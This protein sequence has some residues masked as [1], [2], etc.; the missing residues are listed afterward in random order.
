MDRGE[1]HNKNTNYEEERKE[2]TEQRLA[3]LRSTRPME[4]NYEGHVPLRLSEK[5]LM[6]G[7]SGI[8][9]FFTERM[10]LI[11]FSWVKLQLTLTF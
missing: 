11:S 8:K 4:P 5:L 10:V 9:S 1:L 7:V 2:R 6:F 3:A